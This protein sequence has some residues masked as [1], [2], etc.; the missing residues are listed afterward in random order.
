M[1]V[2]A[3]QKQSAYSAHQAKRTEPVQHTPSQAAKSKTVETKHAESPRPAPVVNTQGQVTG[4]LL[5]ARA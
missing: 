1:D 2:S 4:R 3:V 5:N